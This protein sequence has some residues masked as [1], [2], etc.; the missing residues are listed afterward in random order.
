MRENI[1]EFVI[2]LIDRE[3]LKGEHGWKIGAAERIKN[4]IIN[5]VASDGE[6]K[7]DTHSETCTN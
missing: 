5:Y 6:E 7:E 1:G 4:A 3:Q 2:K